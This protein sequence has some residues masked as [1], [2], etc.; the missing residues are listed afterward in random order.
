ML[1]LQHDCSAANRFER[2]CL[3]NNIQNQ[4]AAVLRTTK[5]LLCFFK[6]SQHVCSNWGLSCLVI[7]ECYGLESQLQATL[8]NTWL[9]WA[10]TGDLSFTSVTGRGIAIGVTKVWVVEGVEHFPAELKSIPL[11]G[12]PIFDDGDVGRIDAGAVEKIPRRVSEGSW[13]IGCEGGWVEVLIQPLCFAPLVNL[14]RLAGQVGAISA[15]LCTRVVA[16]VSSRDTERLSRLEG[17]DCAQFPCSES[18][19]QESI[20]PN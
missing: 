14:K 11:G 17:P 7:C 4:R 10:N 20:F 1:R 6:H 18:V 12:C 5:G 13:C 19:F 3:F 16:S 15:L 2:S 8:H 9:N